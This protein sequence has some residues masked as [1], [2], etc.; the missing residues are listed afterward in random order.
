[1]RLFARAARRSHLARL[2]VQAGEG[3]PGQASTAALQG[4]QRG[5]AFIGQGSGN[6]FKLWVP[7][8]RGCQAPRVSGGVFA[9]NIHAP[10]IGCGAQK[11]EVV[12]AQAV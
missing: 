2:A 1:M 11:S 3:S 12:T 4:S 7:G 10:Q 8:K 6:L 9:A 5:A